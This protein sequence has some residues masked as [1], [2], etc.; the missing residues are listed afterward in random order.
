MEHHPRIEAAQHR[1][2][3]TARQVV[4]TAD[5]VASYRAVRASCAQAVASW[6]A[7]HPAGPT[8]RPVKAGPHKPNYVRTW[9]QQVARNRKVGGA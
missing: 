2:A 8:A 5:A 1:V 7:D 3:V 6:F 4:T 9:K